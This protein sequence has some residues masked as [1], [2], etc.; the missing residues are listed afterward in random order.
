MRV[1]R[2][3]SGEYRVKVNSED[4]RLPCCCLRPGSQTIIRQSGQGHSGETLTPS[5]DFHWTE[6]KTRTKEGGGGGGVRLTE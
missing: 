1:T 4:S 6:R 2:S 5:Q 3:S